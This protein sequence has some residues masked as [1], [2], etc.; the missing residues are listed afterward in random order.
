MGHEIFFVFS[1]FKTSYLLT[2][3]YLSKEEFT[4]SERKGKMLAENWPEW[5]YGVLLLYGQSLAL[6][7]LIATRQLNVVKLEGLLDYG[8]GNTE[9]V[10][11]KLHIHVFHG[12]DMFSKFMFKAG[13]YNSMNVNDDDAQLIKFYCL[14]MALEGNLNTERQ[15]FSLLEIQLNEKY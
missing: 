11:S 6:N 7:H 3:A 4:E 15:L 1:F 14:K 10:H 5:H 9:S 2:Q 8:S 13:K 12:G